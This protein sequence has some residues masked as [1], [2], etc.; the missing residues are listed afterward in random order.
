MGTVDNDGKL[1][2]WS[3]YGDELDLVAPWD[4]IGNDPGTSFS[5]AFVAGLAALLMEDD[6]GMTRDEVLE[7]LNFLMADL[8]TGDDGSQEEGI[9]GVDINEI[10]SEQETVRENREG[11]NGYPIKE[12]GLIDILER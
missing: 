1:S 8:G 7:K 10:L 11:F 6:P 9:K 2:V 4:V 3:N 12:E 5:A